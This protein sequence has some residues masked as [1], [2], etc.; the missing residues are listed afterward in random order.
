MRRNKVSLGFKV[1]NTWY[2]IYKGSQS[3]VMDGGHK[4]VLESSAHKNYTN[5][6]KINNE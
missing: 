5:E 1:D 2:V 3:E 4:R 6:M